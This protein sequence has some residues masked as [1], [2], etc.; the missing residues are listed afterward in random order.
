MVCAPCVTMG[1]EDA[2]YVL[3]PI[4]CVDANGEYAMMFYPGGH[5]GFVVW[6]GEAALHHGRTVRELAWAVASQ[7]VARGVGVAGFRCKTAMI[8]GPLEGIPGESSYATV[9]SGCLRT[10]E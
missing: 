6:Q 1:T 9:S 7:T 5:F 3:L 4:Q 2:T 10:L 8:D